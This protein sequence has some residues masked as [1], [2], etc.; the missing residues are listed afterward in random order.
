MAQGVRDV[1]M[2]ETL[3]L[4]TTTQRNNV[5]VSCGNTGNGQNSLLPE[6]DLGECYAFGEG[7]M[8]DLSTDSTNHEGKQR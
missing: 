2:K 4:F 3:S 8:F 7:K 5:C 1:S 6:R